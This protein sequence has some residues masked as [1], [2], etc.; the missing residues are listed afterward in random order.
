MLIAKWC[1]CIDNQFTQEN[2][3]MKNYTMKRNEIRRN[4]KQSEGWRFKVSQKAA[5][6]HVSLLSD[7]E[8]NNP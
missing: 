7:T 4:E 6:K 1:N 8:K 3:D 2:N 5:H